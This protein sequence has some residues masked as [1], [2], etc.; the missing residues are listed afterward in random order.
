MP[1][2][3]DLPTQAAIEN[4]VWAAWLAETGSDARPFP[5]L[6]RDVPVVVAERIAAELARNA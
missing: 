1:T 5:E 2:T 3:P 4:K 6:V